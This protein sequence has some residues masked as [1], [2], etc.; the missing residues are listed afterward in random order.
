MLKLLVGIKKKKKVYASQMEIQGINQERRRNQIDLPTVI[1]IR[2]PA[3]GTENTRFSISSF[4]CCIQVA[5]IL[6]CFSMGNELVRAS[7]LL[8]TRAADLEENI[9]ALTGAMQVRGRSCIFK[10]VLTR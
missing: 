10:I 8:F 3:T 6:S 2:V 5:T 7:A 1:T 9:D 4:P